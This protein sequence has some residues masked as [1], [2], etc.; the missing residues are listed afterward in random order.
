METSTKK[1]STAAYAIPSLAEKGGSHQMTPLYVAFN[2]P[3]V[4]P[5]HGLMLPCGQMF[6]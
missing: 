5:Q 1:V 6:P 4:F 2:N 3:M